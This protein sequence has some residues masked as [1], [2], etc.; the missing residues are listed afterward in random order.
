MENTCQ[1]ERT[2]LS[3]Q[4]PFGFVRRLGEIMQK[5]AES[6]PREDSAC[7][8]ALP[9]FASSSPEPFAKSKVLEQPAI[10]WL[11]LCSDRQDFIFWNLLYC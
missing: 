8:T 1:S 10:N 4:S 7:T 3:G 6:L 5:M 2:S 11:G 9:G